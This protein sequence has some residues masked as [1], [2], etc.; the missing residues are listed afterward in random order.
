MKPLHAI[1][2]EIDAITGDGE[3]LPDAEARLDALTMDLETKLEACVCMMRNFA[4]EADMLTAEAKRFIE[5]VKI[6]EASEKRIKQYVLNVLTHLGIAK[7][8]AGKFKLRIQQ[9]SV[10][11]TMFDGDPADLPAAFQR[12]KVELNAAVC[13]DAW[14]AGEAL[15]PGV[16]V[17]KGSH[18]RVT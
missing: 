11:T 1:A 15:P 12:V 17:E 8:D 16:K 18:L 6:A 13:V 14:K 4:G 10:P 7:I 3:L 2:A 5:R 9:N